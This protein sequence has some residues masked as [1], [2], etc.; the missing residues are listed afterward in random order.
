MF[1]LGFGVENVAYLQHS[2]GQRFGSVRF[3]SVRSNG[4]KQPLSLEAAAAFCLN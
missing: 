2:S 3:G 1:V 4:R